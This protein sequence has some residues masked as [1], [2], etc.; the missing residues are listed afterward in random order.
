M[1][2]TRKCVKPKWWGRN[3]NT[4][5]AHPLSRHF[6]SSCQKGSAVADKRGGGQGDHSR[7]VKARLS[8]VTGSD[9]IVELI[10]VVVVPHTS[11]TSRHIFVQQRSCWRRKENVTIHRPLFP[12]KADTAVRWYPR[13]IW[14]MHTHCLPPWAWWR[15]GCCC[16]RWREYISQVQTNHE[17]SVSHD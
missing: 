11:V 14:D 9:V 4:N 6:D 10:V 5:H 1:K 2:H 13:A 8:A 12:A 16:L 3:K 15:L 7:F 17:T